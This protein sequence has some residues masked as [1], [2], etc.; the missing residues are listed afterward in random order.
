MSLSYLLKHIIDLI[1]SPLCTLINKSIAEGIFPSILKNTIIKP[2]YKKGNIDDLNNYRPIALV[3]TIS[4]VFE[5]VLLDQLQSYFAER[6]FLNACQYGFRSG[7]GTIHAIEK[8]VNIIYSNLELKRFCYSS[9]PVQGF[10][11]HFS[12][13]AGSKIEILWYVY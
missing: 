4:K 3:P 7:I 12:R 2:I 13:L 9:W 5:S 6:G 8:V 10:R 11:Y 1:I